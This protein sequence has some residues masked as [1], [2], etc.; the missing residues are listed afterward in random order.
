MRSAA[1]NAVV[2]PKIGVRF[3]VSQR[4]EFAK[5]LAPLCRIEPRPQSKQVENRSFLLL[6]LYSLNIIYRVRQ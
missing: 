2:N 3:V 1:G 6:F 4:F 5:S